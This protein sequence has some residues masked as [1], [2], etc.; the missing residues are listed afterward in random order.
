MLTRL[1][2]R[3]LLAE[4]VGDEIWSLE[5]CR[6]KG[7]P[8]PWIEELVDTFESGFRYEDQT[9]YVRRQVTNQYRGVRD[10]D[11]AVRLAEFLGV[12]SDAVIA[13]ALGPRA[14]VSALQEAVEEG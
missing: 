1:H 3:M 6:D 2:A 7:I 10:R 12:A 9:I 11:L 13:L 8:E 5:L 4:C 14:E